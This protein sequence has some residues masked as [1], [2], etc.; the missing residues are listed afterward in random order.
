MSL[1]ID[2]DIP[3]IHKRRKPENELVN[4]FNA[5]VRNKAVSILRVSTEA[6]RKFVEDASEQMLINEYVEQL[7]KQR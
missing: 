2:Y 7:E 5:L 3:G 6:S 4:N 1:G